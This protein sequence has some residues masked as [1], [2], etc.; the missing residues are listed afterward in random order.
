MR[1]IEQLRN[2]FALYIDE[3]ERCE[4][5]K[6]Y[7]ALL[8]VLLALPDVCATLE[9]DPARAK[10]RVGDR[11]VDWCAAYLP[12]SPTVSGADRYQMR[13]ALLHSGST[14]AQNLGKAHQ[15]GYVY[16]SYVDP[17][18]FDVSVHYTTNQG[19]TVL[20][21]H[22]AAMTAET[23]QALES[24]FGTLQRDPI[25]MSLVEQNIR[26]LTRLQAK[27]IVVTESNGSEIEKAGLTRSST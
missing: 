16:F 3:I 26:L 15:T 8:H 19:H 7:W 21:V 14:A 23:K 25:K 22:V 9:T 18:T 4:N 20:N 5:A 6:C 1:T 12:K 11:Y 13:N 10:P 17:E 2:D 27:R 24:W